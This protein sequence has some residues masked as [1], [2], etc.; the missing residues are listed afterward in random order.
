MQGADMTHP[1]KPLTTRDLKS[2]LASMGL[3]FT[4]R[5][6][7]QMLPLMAEQIEAAAR[8]R[9]VRLPNDAPMA[10]RFDPRLAG[11]EMPDDMPVGLT[12]PPAAR[13]LPESDTDIAF[14]PLPDLAH[15]I[16]TRQITSR[17]LTE[18]YLDR[19]ARHGPRLLCFAT[20]M[21]ESAL[22][23]AEACDAMTAKSE[24]RG[25]LHGLPYGIK[26][27]FDTAGVPT[28]WGA[29][30]YADRV[31]EQ[32]AAVVTRLRAAG[33]VL[34]GK[35]ALGAM[36]YGDLWYGGRCRN[37]W[38]PDEGSSGSS[39]GSASA[40]AAGLCA[41]AIG[42][43]TLGSIVSPSERCGATGLRPTFGRVSRAGAM[44]LC[45]SLDKVGPITRGV[46]DCAMVLDALNAPDPAD[47]G[48][49]AAPFGADLTRGGERLRIGMVAGTMADAPE[50]VVAAINALRAMRYEI[51]DVHLPDLPY[52]SLQN[53]LLA[54]AAA[55][56]ADLTESDRDDLLSWQD[57]EA[58]P[59]TF[60]RARLLSAVDHVQLDRLR[61]RVMEAFDA[62]FRE[63][64]VL[65]GPPFAGPLLVATNFTGHPCL[66][67]KAGLAAS[68]PRDSGVIGQ[69]VP[70][71]KPAGAVARVP[72]GV[73][74]WAGLYAEHHLLTVGH[75]IEA[76]LA[77]RDS[78][79]P[80][81]DD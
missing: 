29:E 43:E 15:W 6:R 17:R 24:S 39:A 68:T 74:L 81:F 50:G 72:H 45:W 47:R 30:P 42:T 59:N 12:L 75:E 28:G 26:D 46:A 1:V 14:A 32:D 21:A 80:A 62:A 4:A 10:L 51:H 41:F 76:A 52:D 53:I 11:F 3:D 38:N 61:F 8:W 54:E 73:S 79:P 33:A 35:T 66:H 31:P 63:V 48:S 49:I 78:R 71:A 13:P 64:D 18:I 37:P 25:P 7:R 56:F 22:A 27:L 67:L 2:A 40:A 69:S 44:T 70:A 34:L 23:E 9:R 5:E 36:A 57:D 55:A 20:V 65:I 77:V 19:I 16:A 58:W 60:R